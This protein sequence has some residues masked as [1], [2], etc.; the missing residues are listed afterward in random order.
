MAAHRGLSQPGG[1]LSRDCGWLRR[2][3]APPR[4]RA[5]PLAC[6]EAGPC[7]DPR[8]GRRHFAAP[9]RD[10]DAPLCPPAVPDRPLRESGAGSR[11]QA[12]DSHTIGSC[13]S[14]CWC[15]CRRLRGPRAPPFHGRAG[16]PARRPPQQHG[17][18]GVPRPAAGGP[19]PRRRR[20]LH[21]GGRPGRQ[22][23]RRAPL[24]RPPEAARVSCMEAQSRRWGRSDVG[25]RKH[26]LRQGGSAR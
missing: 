16:R 14:C 8:L 10:P 4:A 15:C 5:R 23:L 7:L 18:E 25:R 12:A 9:A 2:G 1:I 13:S 3:D 22:G 6:Q 24:F 17:S 26:R 20:G 11:C 19:W 21:A